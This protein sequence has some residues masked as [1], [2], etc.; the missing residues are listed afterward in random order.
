MISREGTPM[1]VQRETAPRLRR[2][3]VPLKTYFARVVRT[4]RISPQM[5]RITLGEG[6]LPE[7]VSAAPDQFITLLLPLP[8]QERPVVTR[9]LRWE[10]FREMPEEVRPTARNYTVRQHRPEVAELDVDFVMHGDDGPASRWA[11]RAQPGDH[12]AIWGPRMAYDPPGDTIWQLLVADETGLPAVGAILEALPSGTRVH[13][14]I[15]VADRAEAQALTS[16]G[17]VT[18]TWLYRHGIPAGESDL[19]IDAVRAATLPDGLV[20]V[21]GGGERRVMSEVRRHLQD[22]RG[23][24]ADAISILNYWRRDK[25]HAS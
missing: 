11:A 15:E 2:Q 18:I 8:G 7:F 4:A 1:S 25:G 17:D 21:W 13:A 9:D 14:F 22:E 12:L 10:A 16:A 3:P 5:L 19:L 24:A 20:Y 23:I 6:D